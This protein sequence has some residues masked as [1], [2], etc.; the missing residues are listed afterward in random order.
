M[1][2]ATP[3]VSPTLAGVSSPVEAVEALR[4]VADPAERARAAG[5][6]LGELGV[7]IEAAKLCRREA[8]LELRAAGYSHGQVAAELGVARGRAQQIAEGRSTGKRAEPA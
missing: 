8:V 2:A 6:L 4:Q 5:A 3:L 1:G 7:A